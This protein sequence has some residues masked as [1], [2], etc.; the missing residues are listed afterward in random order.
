MHA[1]AQFFH[2]ECNTQR[3]DTQKT[4]IDNTSEPHVQQSE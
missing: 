1:T 3:A 4:R 2:L